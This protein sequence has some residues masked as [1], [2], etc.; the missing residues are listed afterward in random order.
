MLTLLFLSLEA[1]WLKLWA[2][3]VDVGGSLY[4]FYQSSQNTSEGF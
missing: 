2:L 3:L 4:G 1:L